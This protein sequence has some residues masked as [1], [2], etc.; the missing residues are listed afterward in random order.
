METN[1]SAA[2][3]TDVIVTKLTLFTRDEIIMYNNATLRHT[4]QIL[5]IL[6]AYEITN[7]CSCGYA[8]AASSSEDLLHML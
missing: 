3:C 5:G 6:C 1:S 4:K 2:E 8:S 7:K